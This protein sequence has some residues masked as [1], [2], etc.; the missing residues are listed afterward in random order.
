MKA[1]SISGEADLAMLHGDVARSAM[2][3]R[4]MQALER[5]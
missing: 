1:R 5:E 4:G 3:V 2:Q